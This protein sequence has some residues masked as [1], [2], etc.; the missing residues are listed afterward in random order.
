MCVS[1]TSVS[2]SESCECDFVSSRGLVR[3]GLRKWDFFEVCEH[4]VMLTF[5]ESTPFTVDVFFNT[6]EEIRMG[7]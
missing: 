2:Y 3:G 7:W 6:V 5:P 4:V 1:E